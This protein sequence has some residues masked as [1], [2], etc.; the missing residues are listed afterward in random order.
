MVVGDIVAMFVDS[1]PQDGVCQLV[2][3]RGDL[4]SS[5]Y[6]GVW[7]LCGVYGV[8]HD[9]QI[10]AGRIFHAGRNIKAADGQAVLLIFYRT[11]TD[12]YI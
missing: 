9:R 3:G 11:G 2:A 6:K 10:S 5:V 4:P 1:T 7:M 12:G 8:Q